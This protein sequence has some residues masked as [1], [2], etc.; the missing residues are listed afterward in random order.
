MKININPEIFATNAQ[1]F[2][3]LDAKANM[4]YA[5]PAAQPL[6]A[7]LSQHRLLWLRELLKAS[8]SDEKPLHH[9]TTESLPLEARNWDI[10][11][12][13]A[14]TSEY[15]LWFKPLASAA[16]AKTSNIPGLSLIG[17]KMRDEMTAY[18]GMLRDHFSSLKDSTAVPAHFQL[19]AKTLHISEQMDELAKLSELQE[20]NPTGKEE[21]IYLYSL[22]NQLIS[23]TPSFTSSHIE[24]I[25][26]P[27]GA[28]L[29]P[30]F[31]DKAWLT[32]ALRAYFKKLAE[33]AADGGAI[34]LQ[35]QQIGGHASLTGRYQPDTS[36]PAR[37]IS[38]RQPAQSE[39]H[40][41]DLSLQLAERVLELHGATVTVQHLPDQKRF[42]SVRIIFPTA[43]PQTTRPDVWCQNCPAVDQSA[44]FARDIATL[45]RVQKN[46]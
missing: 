14:E 3:L 16:P 4:V 42:E 25:V 17:Q 20:R 40:V 22:C 34:H 26:D 21:R 18:A 19:M 33:C 6:A 45:T 8:S 28:L 44:A 13:S 39:E 37:N 1:P 23:Q 31:G 29:A 41:F 30:V 38:H 7:M 12:T 46:D 24:W 35:F 11:L 2:M 43:S 32:L 27:S 15:A 9:L 10:W 36:T 5:N